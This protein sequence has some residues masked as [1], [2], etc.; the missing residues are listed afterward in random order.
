MWVI[1][2]STVETAT[3]SSA[4]ISLVVAARGQQPQDLD[5]G[6]GEVGEGAALPSAPGTA[7]ISAGGATS[8]ASASATASSTDSS[9]PSAQAAA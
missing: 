2:R 9:L 4:A 7:G 6:R 8:T 1:W 5:F 3:T